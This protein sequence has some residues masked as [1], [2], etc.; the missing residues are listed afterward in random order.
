MK[1]PGVGAKKR[2][3]EIDI[4]GE[5]VSKVSKANLMG[6]QQ[7]HYPGE[8]QQTA[9]NLEFHNEIDEFL[10][11]QEED[12]PKIDSKDNFVKMLKSSKKDSK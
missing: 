5:L 9:M 11:D 2:V 6:M 3:K 12:I 8:I 1:V 10:M 4:D 7:P